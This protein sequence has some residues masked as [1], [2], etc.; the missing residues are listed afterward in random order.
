LKPHLERWNRSVKDEC[1]WKLILFGEASLR[2]VRWDC[3]P[4]GQVNPAFGGTIIGLTNGDKITA[5]YSCAATSNS[6]ARTNPIVPSL[7][8]TNS[9]LGNYAVTINVGTLTIIGPPSIQSATLAS[10]AFSFS[11][12][13]ATNTA[14]QIQ[15][16]TNLAN[17]AWI[18]LGGELISTN[19][20][21]MFTDTISN[22]QKYYRVLLLP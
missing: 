15:Y 11:W 14:Y 22:S 19:S 1:L 9:R 5:T 3:A 4:F 8:D 20:T 6:P 17:S 18:N 21:A 10:N 13:A 12:S 2:H 7:V 16:S